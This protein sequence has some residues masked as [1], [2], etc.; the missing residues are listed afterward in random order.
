MRQEDKGCREC[1]AAAGAVDAWKPP[2]LA[3]RVLRESLWLLSAWGV[4]GVFSMAA[5]DAVP[6]G[7]YFNVLGVLLLLAVGSAGVQTLV[8]V[9]KFFVVFLPRN[10][11]AK[12]RGIYLF[13]DK[14]DRLHRHLAVPIATAYAAT[15]AIV[16]IG[17]GR[18]L[19]KTVTIGAP[20]L[21]W[22]VVGEPTLAEL[23][24]E[25]QHGCRLPGYSHP[26]WVL[27]QIAKYVNVDSLISDTEARA[28]HFKRLLAVLGAD[29]QATI[30]SAIAGKDAQRSPQT[31]A[32]RERLEKALADLRGADCITDATLA[33]WKEDAERLLEEEQRAAVVEEGAAKLADELA[34]ARAV[35]VR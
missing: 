30:L 17:V 4:A 25:D 3:K 29:V 35:G 14:E 16:G 8:S 18:W 19:R 28:A 27:A 15:P 31:K 2:V 10:V 13:L 12:N 9:V 7:Y 24:V 21:N 26:A 1:E 23:V 5:N 22:K 20:W 34:T 32:L 11:F 33:E 6:A